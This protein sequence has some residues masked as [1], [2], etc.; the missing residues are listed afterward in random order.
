MHK[1]ILERLAAESNLRQLRSVSS[2]GA[3]IKYQGREYLNFSS[4]DY[5]G[6]STRSDLQ[7]QF[8]DQL[9][10]NDHSSFLMSNPSS[11]LV[12][13]NSH[14]YDDLEICLA[15]LYGAEAALVLGSGYLLNSGALGALTTE[16]DLVIA[17]RLMH[18]SLIDGMR[19]A[20]APWER[21][22]HNDMNHLQAILERTAARHERVIVATESVFSMDG[23]Q[24]PIAEIMELKARY[25]FELYLD[26]AHAFGVYGEHGTGLAPL[27]LDIEYRVA[28][29]GKAACS[30]GAFII[31]SNE[32]RNLMI[33]RMRTAIFSTALPP[34]NLL[35]SRLMIEQL[36]KM[37]AERAHL[38]ELI[39]MVGGQSH[40]IPVI[41]G[42]NKSTCDR[43]AELLEQ[44]Y[45]VSAIRHPTV[46]EGMARLRISLTA[47]HT[48]EQVK[49]LWR[50]IG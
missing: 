24:A 3:M 35:W 9:L 29:L 20:S 30:T 44:G 45:W 5:L 40:I 38:Q 11:R 4:N 2:Q 21:F 47:A 15:K 17:D 39:N 7:R 26:E 14:H 49:E 42:D 6:L 22:R 25:G 37:D 10:E 16:R 50:H 28:T 32:S 41:T 43:A 8:L 31:C 33:N 23:D 12:T 19:L 18:A 46:P 36:S 1:Q 27:D 13:G 48:A 34:I